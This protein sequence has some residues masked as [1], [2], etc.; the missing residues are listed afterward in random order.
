ML[1]LDPLFAA[2][3][4][5]AHSLPVSRKPELH[6]RGCQWPG[7]EGTITSYLDDSGNGRFVGGGERMHMTGAIS[8]VSFPSIS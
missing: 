1:C 5:K 8:I 7:N 6:G 2:A 3:S 4:R